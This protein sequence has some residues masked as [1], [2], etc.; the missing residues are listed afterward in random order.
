MPWIGRKKL[1]FVPVYRPRAVPPDVIPPNWEGEIY[2]RA[3]YDPDPLTRQDRS[4]R[5]YIHT[6]SSG[7]ADLDAV[8]LPLEEVDQQ[9]VPPGILEGKLGPALREQGVDCAAIVML[10]GRGAGTSAGFWV[11]FVMLENVGVW[12]MEFMH[13][14]TG[15]AD[16][17]VFN[18]T[19]GAFDE[20][21]C[22]CGT[23]PSAYTKAAVGWLDADAIAAHSGRAR[24]YHLHAVGLVQPPPSGRAAAVKVGTEV[25]YFMVEARTMVDQFESRSQ[26]DPGIP[27]EGV[28]VYRIQTTDPL[29][30]AQNE[31]APV[32]LLTRAALVPGQAI[33]TDT[34]VTVSVTGA[35]P[36]GYLVVVDDRNA[37]AEVGQLLFYRD[38]TRNGTGDVNTPAVIG[39]GG[40]QQFSRLFSGG[41]GILYAVDGAGRLLFYRD[42][43]RDGTGD[44]SSPSVIGQGG[45][46]QF[47]HLFS[48]G[49]GIIYAVDGDGRLLFYRDAAQNGTGDVA[50]PSVIGHGGWQGFTHLFS[51]G[52]GI[53]YAVDSDGRL[54]FYRDTTQDGTGDV[55]SPGIIGQGG[56]QGFRHLFGGGDGIIYAVDGDG[57]LLF[58]RDT[59]QDGTG[60]VA[61]PSVIGQGGW[62]QFKF[63]FS[64]GDGIIYAVAG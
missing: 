57:R 11:R 56:W 36:G 32:D 17:Y 62:Q 58:Y 31:K 38:T 20:M 42:W 18:S 3:L 49:N 43:R 54:L 27:S 1:A 24:P 13:S 41:N 30:R 59:T 44:V 53:I 39:L 21:S 4:L 37:P 40:W 47:L 2:R 34:N 46:Q 26:L 60:D 51:G 29:G 19:I 8:V 22:S 25:P 35:T 9:D 6:V 15:F 45:W 52:N 28:I 64:G 48:G 23:H 63:L 5:A 55:S 33:T 7:R 10:G 61:N 50:N 14:L 12:A 16:L